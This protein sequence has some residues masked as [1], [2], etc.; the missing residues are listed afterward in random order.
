[1][2]AADILSAV[3]L[4][5]PSA[6]IVHEM[7]VDDEA[8]RTA[9]RAMY[10]H[11]RPHLSR[12]VANHWGEV[13]PYTDEHKAYLETGKAIRR[14]DALMM[15]GTKRTAIEVKVTRADFKRDTAQKRA[16]WAAITHRFVYA[17]PA[18]LVTPEEV[19]DGCGLWE[20]RGDGRVDVTK[21][22]RINKDAAD[23]PPQ[24]ILALAYRA[25]KNQ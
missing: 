19:P 5:Y 8:Y 17:V 10:A 18:G 22:A 7:V 16:P 14:I 9:Y 4:K 6:A 20:V 24:I 23:L 3:R 2:R 12:F 25:M 15:A 1:M 13:D 21:R 11:N